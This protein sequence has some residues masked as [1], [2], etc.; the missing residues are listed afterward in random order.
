MATPEEFEARMRALGTRVE[1]G[2]WRVAQKA[3]LAASQA[4]IVAT[5]V[6]TG[7]ARSNWLLSMNSPREEVIEPL[8]D[9]EA[10]T[11]PAIDAAQAVIATY[12]GARDRSIHITN[13]VDYI[14]KLNDGWS[15][16]AP[17]GYVRMA[18]VAG[19]AAVRGARVL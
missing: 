16:Q 12:S 3:A 17:R 6:D 5:P 19:V 7:R 11:Q 15:A 10:A 9:G 18:V 13:S 2:S 14:G 1:A 4:V 8:A